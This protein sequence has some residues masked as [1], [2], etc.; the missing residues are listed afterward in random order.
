MLR[1][2]GGAAIDFER[3]AVPTGGA[4][5]DAAKAGACRRALCTVDSGSLRV[6][7]DGDAATDSA[8]HKLEAG[9]SLLIERRDQALKAN[10]RRISP[11]T[12]VMQ[13]TYLR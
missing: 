9:D 4:S 10:F 3:L 13:V 6:R 11:A 7:L 5:L 12:C 8:G 1:T 2:L